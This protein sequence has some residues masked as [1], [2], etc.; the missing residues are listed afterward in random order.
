MKKTTLIFL[1]LVLTGICSAQLNYT[2][3]MDSTSAWRISDGTIYGKGQEYETIVLLVYVAGDTIINNVN[4]TRLLKTGYRSYYHWN[5]ETTYSYYKGAPYGH[6]RSD[7]K[8]TYWLFENGERLLY[9]FSLQV[10]DHLPDN[11]ISKNTTIVSSIDTVVVNGK[12]LRRFNLYD[13]VN[14]EL[15]SRWYIQGIGHE[16]GLI[17]PMYG[18]G[19]YF[20]TL[21]CYVENGVAVFPEGSDC[22]LSLGI[23]QAVKSETPF[24]IYPN[25]SKG[26]FNLTYPSNKTK[27]VEIQIAGARGDI[28]TTTKWHVQT[29]QNERNFNL[30]SVNPG[31]YVVIVRDGSAIA[32]RKFFIIR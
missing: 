16:H 1:S 21:D 25:P 31:L 26:L 15:Q 5:G 29:G 20:Y 2:I 18:S 4:Y 13:T 14:S 17:A 28:I 6:F 24:S 9:D 23:E 22:D 27:K 32:A 30:N 8:C 12:S 10:G 11:G 7:S 19:Y 3:P